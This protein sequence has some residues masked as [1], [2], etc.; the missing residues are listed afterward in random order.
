MEKGYKNII[1]KN[2]AWEKGVN[3][4]WRP[5]QQW[6]KKKENYGEKQN[7]GIYK[8]NDTGIIFACRSW[9]SVKYQLCFSL[10][11]FSF[12]PALTSNWTAAQLTA[13][14]GRLT[15]P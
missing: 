15:K 8:E 12:C 11:P 2:T 4:V 13:G 3:S 5:A 9:I 6:W 7:K 10:P 14:C 1:S